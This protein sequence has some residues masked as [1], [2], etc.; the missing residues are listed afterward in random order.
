MST[1]LDVDADAIAGPA[2]SFSESTLAPSP[3]AESPAPTPSL[4]SAHEGGYRHFNIQEQLSTISPESIVV[5]HG[6]TFVKT[7]D[8]AHFSRLKKHS[9]VWDHGTQ[10]LEVQS[11]KKYW[12]C[13]HCM[14]IGC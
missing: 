14:F 2:S 3:S 13:N 8:L 1:P 4:V 6:K 11:K 12:L 10:L 9:K 7:A 5:T